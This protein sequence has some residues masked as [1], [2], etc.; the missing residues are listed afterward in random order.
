MKKSLWVIL[1]TVLITLLLSASTAQAG[2]LSPQTQM[3]SQVIAGQEYFTDHNG[4]LAP[5]TIATQ[6]FT[7]NQDGALSLTTLQT[8][9]LAGVMLS[10][11][12]TITLDGVTIFNQDYI[13]GSK[14][15][16]TND[17][18]AAITLTAPVLAGAHM[19]V[20]SYSAMLD[21]GQPF[22]TDPGTVSLLVSSPATSN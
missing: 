4:V 16:G 7:T 9:K 6:S 3:F 14:Q 11:T 15:F 19:L 5:T 20:I 2:K 21:A 10:I 12:V 18:D 1:V 8:L 22:F 17:I 13:H